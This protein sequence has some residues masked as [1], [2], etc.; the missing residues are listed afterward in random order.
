MVAHPTE[1]ETSRMRPGIA[2][3]RKAK[4]KSAVIL[5]V[6]MVSLLRVLAAHAE[7]GVGTKD[8]SL[9]AFAEAEAQA[10]IDGRTIR[11]A[12]G[13]DVRLA[14]VEVPDSANENNG[15]DAVGALNELV[16]GRDVVLKH[17]KPVTDR[18]GRIVAWLFVKSA[19]GE[20]LVAAALVGQGRAMVSPPAGEGACMSVLLAAERAAR[21]GKLGLWGQP[22]RIR[23]RLRRHGV[24]FRWSKDGCCRSAKAAASSM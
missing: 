6:A 7:D 14:G 5:I 2:L 10:A 3:R 23:V 20:H 24:A 17:S 13:R 18:Y 8:C 21:A 1:H 12:D 11:L 15:F 16:A 4:S 22:R 9:V 19:D